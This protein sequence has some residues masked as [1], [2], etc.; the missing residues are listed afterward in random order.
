MTQLKDELI[1]QLV[2]LEVYDHHGL[3]YQLKSID[4]DEYVAQ[5][6]QTVANHLPE[7]RKLIEPVTNREVSDNDKVGIDL[8]VDTRGS[9]VFIQNNGFNQAIQEMKD[10]LEGKV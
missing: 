9:L 10:I 4:I 5:I 8:D 1:E 7:K 6:L 3:K 2:D